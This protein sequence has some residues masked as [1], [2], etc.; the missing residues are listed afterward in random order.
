MLE[1]GETYKEDLK[2]MIENILEGWYNNLSTLALRGLLV[3]LLKDIP[4]NVASNLY[5]KCSQ[6]SIYQLI[7]VNI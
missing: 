5:H 7:K 3:I 6:K 2:S 4:K 1:N